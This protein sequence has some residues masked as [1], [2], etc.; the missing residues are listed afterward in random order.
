MSGAVGE[1]SLERRPGK[2][3]LVGEAS[4]AEASA[5]EESGTEGAAA[6]ESAGEE[7]VWEEAVLVKAVVEAAWMAQVGF[8][9]SLEDCVDLIIVGRLDGDYVVVP[10]S[11]LLSIGT[12]WSIPR[13][14]AS[15]T[16][17]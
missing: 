7:T 8:L 12:S 13:S 1:A 5:R 6:E 4:V 2:M 17:L 15:R 3:E 14:A 16:G 11:D 10:C 9:Q